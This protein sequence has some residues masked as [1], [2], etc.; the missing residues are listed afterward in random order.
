MHKRIIVSLGD[1][2]KRSQYLSRHSLCIGQG[3]VAPV[4]FWRYR[5]PGEKNTF[6]TAPGGRNYTSINMLTSKDSSCKGLLARMCLKI[7][8]SKLGWR[9]CRNC[10]LRPEMFNF[11][12]FEDPN[13]NLNSGA[14]N[15]ARK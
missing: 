14:E 4:S 11:E 9:C 7:V 15:N 8:L 2:K 10:V 3:S 12:M 13:N 6:C 1:N 5:T